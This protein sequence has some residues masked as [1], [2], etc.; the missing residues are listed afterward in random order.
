V[1]AAT[2]GPQPLARSEAEDGG[3]SDLVASRGMPQLGGRGRRSRMSH[4][5]QRSTSAASVLWRVIRQQKPIWTCAL[6]GAYGR[7]LA[8]R[9]P[10]FWS[11]ATPLPEQALCTGDLIYLPRPDAEGFSSSKDWRIAAP[12]QTGSLIDTRHPASCAGRIQANFFRA[13]VRRESGNQISLKDR[14]MTFSKIRLRPML[15]S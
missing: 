4:C 10:A 11:T 6:S 8:Q 1:S 12:E 2:T 14:S 7:A 13:T 15:S 5:G 3:P 9:L